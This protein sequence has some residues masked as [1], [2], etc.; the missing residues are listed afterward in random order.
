MK[1]S[2]GCVYALALSRI[3]GSITHLLLTE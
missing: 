2:R 1:D 3:D